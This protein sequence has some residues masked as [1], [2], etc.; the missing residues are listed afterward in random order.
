MGKNTRKLLVESISFVLGGSKGL[1]IL[2]Q[3]C[4]TTVVSSGIIYEFVKGFS[5]CIAVLGYAGGQEGRTGVIAIF[6]SF[7]S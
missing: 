2:S 7:F 4:H 3:S 6:L 5:I 1:T